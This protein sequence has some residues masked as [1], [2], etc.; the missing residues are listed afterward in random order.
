MRW[1]YLCFFLLGCAACNSPS[2]TPPNPFT[3]HLSKD[4]QSVYI[5]GLDYAALQ[6]LKKDTLT[7]DAWQSLFPVYSMPAD[8]TMKDFQQEQP[9]TYTVGDSAVN[10]KPDTAFKKMQLYFVRFYG[11][12]SAISTLKLLQK[13]ANLKGPQYIEAVFKF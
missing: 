2:A 5:R 8:T 9:G 1:L 4:S 3:I 7:R 13:K 10:F 11:N 12:N 6:Q